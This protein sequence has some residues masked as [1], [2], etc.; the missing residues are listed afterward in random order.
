MNHRRIAAASV[1]C[2]LA[3]LLS[4]CGTFSS[5]TLPAYD[6]SFLRPP[7]EVPPGLA[8]PVNQGDLSSPSVSGFGAGSSASPMQTVL[9]SF[10]GMRLVRGGCQR[11]LVVQAQPAQLWDLIRQFVKD[12]GLQIAQE[13]R[14]EGTVDTAWHAVLPYAAAATATTPRV[15]GARAIYRFRLERGMHPGNTELY[16]S[17]R[18]VQEVATDHGN[19]WES[20]PPDPEAEA[21]MLRAFM[22]FAGAKVQA[23]TA[24]A[25]R[26][27][28]LALDAQGNT[29]LNFRDSLDN[30]WRRVGIALERIGWLVHD[31]DRSKWTYRVQQARAGSGK[32][33]F[34]GR[35][36]G[37]HAATSGP[38][39]RVV[40]HAANGGWVELLLTKADGAPVPKAIAEPLLKQLY[41]QL[42]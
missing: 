27:A 38:V 41:E 20:A 22:V 14:R 12:R 34:F 28:S 32:P 7:L 17:R 10:P 33:G 42:K 8:Q 30:G 24:P 16:I 11:W 39:Y 15:L 13:S 4:A 3:L 29:V 6:N 1:A 37:R 40:L 26:Q 31:R 25:S 9:P 21:R 35:L 19:A 23:G 2:A 18:A 36:F 5:R